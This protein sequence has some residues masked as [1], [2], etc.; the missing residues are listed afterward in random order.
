[1][2]SENEIRGTPFEIDINHDLSLDIEG[3]NIEADLRNVPLKEIEQ[4]TRNEKIANGVAATEVA[5]SIF[6]ILLNPFSTSVI[7][8]GVLGLTIAPVLAFSQKELADIVSLEAIATRMTDELDFLQKENT[9]LKEQIEKLRHTAGRLEELEGA[10]AKTT[11][12]QI[13]NVGEFAEQVEKM[14]THSK[15]L[16]DNISDKIMT[17]IIDAA[18]KFDID[19]ND[20]LS[21]DEAKNVIGQVVDVFGVQ[22]KEDRFMDIVRRDRTI[23]GIMVAFSTCQKSEDPSRKLFETKKVA[24]STSQKS[25]DPSMKLFIPAGN[26]SRR[27]RLLPVLPK[28]RKI[29]A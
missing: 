17:F 18:I 15:S 27:K 5:L 13:G 29:P 1:M 16:E 14:R 22:L 10:F 28:N 26:F 23:G 20:Q 7:A 12:L 3:G 25:E 6:A 21:D 24:S 19:G 9:K 11:E 4:Y 8:M 2:Q